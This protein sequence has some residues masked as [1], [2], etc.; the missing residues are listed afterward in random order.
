MT[1][2]SRHV[3]T[4]AVVRHAASIARSELTGF[5]GAHGRKWAVEVTDTDRLTFWQLG[6]R[7]TKRLIIADPGTPGSSDGTPARPASI[8]VQDFDRG[9]FINDPRKTRKVLQSAM[10]SVF[11]E[12]P[13]TEPYLDY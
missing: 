8:T 2:R 6:N 9:T 3:P 5:S 10:R 13:S 1:E 12:R 4:E 7:G 11:G